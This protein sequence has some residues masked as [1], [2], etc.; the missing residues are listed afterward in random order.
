[1]HKFE[2]ISKIG[3]LG[4][5]YIFGQNKTK[6]TKIFWSFSI[7][8]SLCGF[9][10]YLHPAWIKL[11]ITPE[12]RMK[13]IEK[14]VANFPWPAI[15]ICPNIFARRDLINFD[16]STFSTIKN[17]TKEE[18]KIYFANLQW[19]NKKMAKNLREFCSDEFLNEVNVVDM[20]LNTSLNTKELFV[21]PSKIKPQATVL[22]SFGPCYTFNSLSYASLFNTENIHD[23]FKQYKNFIKKSLIEDNSTWTHEKGLKLANG[24]YISP[25]KAYQMEISFKVS[26]K[27]LENVCQTKSFNIFIHKPN[28]VITDRH[29]PFIQHYNEVINIEIFF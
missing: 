5:K 26:A 15:T 28:E 14:K 27:D 13:T 19:C 4:F 18:C 25:P 23:D 29:E 11:M 17:F 7:L 20:I 10:Y 16:Y 3:I 8:L 2:N 6:S 22:S 1:M 9:F 21:T 24:S 12:I